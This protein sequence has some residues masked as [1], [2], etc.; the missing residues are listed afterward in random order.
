MSVSH[1]PLG[2]RPQADPGN[3]EWAVYRG[4][5]QP[6][7]GIDAL[8]SPPPWRRF[9]GAPLIDQ[10]LEADRTGARRL[11][12]IDR[13]RSYRA[14]PQVVEM[15]NAALLL[16]RP[17]LVT[18]KPGT[19][20]STLAYSIAYELRLG[21]VLA[22]SITSRSNLAEGLYRYDGI[23]R[24]QE[25]SLHQATAPAD[26][27]TVPDIGRYI[28]LGPLGTALLPWPRPRVLLIDEMDKSDIDLP[29]DLLHVFEEG[30]Y[31]IPELARLPEDLDV[32]DVMAADSPKRVPVRRGQVNC[33]S[34]PVVVITSNNEREFP[35]AFLRRCIRLDIKP[36][37]PERLASII[38][39]QLGPEA[40]AASASLIEE[41]LERREHGDLAT[42]QLLNAIYIATSGSQPVGKRIIDSLLRPLDPTGA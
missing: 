8:A 20:K 41:F 21:P 31:E 9:E 33:S 18:G 4:T 38:E 14:D 19:G 29:S 6:H 30:R 42:D 5:G 26:R 34:F 22:W 1:E 39:A 16:R 12:A 32:V 37:D 3:A 11:G 13:A 35:P 36:P 23:G 24:L 40:V 15:V 2:S 28:H 25:A 7:D 27:P 17:L 10:K